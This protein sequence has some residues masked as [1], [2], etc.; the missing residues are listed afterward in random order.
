MSKAEHCANDDQRN[1]D[2]APPPPPRC[3]SGKLKDI[4]LALDQSGQHWTLRPPIARSVKNSAS[5]S[6]TTKREPAI[7]PA[8]WW[9]HDLEKR[10]P[11]TAYR[12]P[13]QT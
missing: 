7:D 9:H 11:G 3:C 5:P 1:N 10:P 4:D 8:G 2:Q 13:R 6:T 12:P